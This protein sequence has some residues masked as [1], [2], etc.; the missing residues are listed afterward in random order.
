MVVLKG[1]FD[2]SDDKKT[3]SLSGY[4]ASVDNWNSFERDWN[5]VLA[6]YEIPYLHMKDFAHF[7]KPFDKFKDNEPD[8]VKCLSSLIAI[9]R[10]NSLT[11]ITSII[12]YAGLSKFNDKVN[13]DIIGYSFNL[14][15]CMMIMCHHYKNQNI[16]IVLDRTNGLRHK[17]DKA[18]NYVETDIYYP[19]CDEQIFL[20]PLPKKGLSFREIPPLQA[21]DLLA[22]ESR[23]DFTTKESWIKKINKGDDL[24]PRFLGLR[25]YTKTD[26]KLPYSRKSMYELVK[27]IPTL[28][29][30]WD[31]EGLCRIDNARQHIW[32]S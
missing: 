27:T 5:K 20:L 9:I 1:Y 4:I 18:I 31:Y 29:N 28:G 12:R 3:C 23:K 22:W 13:K 24:N 11:G 6:E 14:Y 21:A 7:K 25:T 10:E 26:D 17:M 30:A 16:E 15:W 8:R 2:D 19:K 32:P